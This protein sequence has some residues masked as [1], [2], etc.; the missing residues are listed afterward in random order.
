MQ[1]DA[2]ANVLLAAKLIYQ[3]REDRPHW[4][5]VAAIADFLAQHWHEPDHGIWAQALSWLSARRPSPRR[6]GRWRCGRQRR[7]R[8]VR[9]VST[10]SIDLSQ[11]WID[12]CFRKETI[13]MHGRST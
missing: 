1:L 5:T 11:L 2:F 10:L 4:N 6:R 13:A 8:L 12:A 7:P 3:R 9:G